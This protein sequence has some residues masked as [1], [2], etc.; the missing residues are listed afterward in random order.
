[1]ADGRL[2][3][4]ESDDRVRLDDH[5]LSAQARTDVS[6]PFQAELQAGRRTE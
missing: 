5:V 1:V 2:D 6:R 4:N 3:D